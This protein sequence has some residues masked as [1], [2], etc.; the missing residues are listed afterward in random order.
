M[1][2]AIKK[3]SLEDIDYRKWDLYRKIFFIKR[4]INI[5]L[6]P[7]YILSFIIYSFSSYLTL[8]VLFNFLKLLTASIQATSFNLIFSFSIALYLISIYFIYTLYKYFVT[9]LNYFLVFRWYYKQ[10]KNRLISEVINKFISEKNKNFDSIDKFTKALE[11][12]FSTFI[13][14]FKGSTVFNLLKEVSESMRK[15]LPLLLYFSN[16]NTIL[17]TESELKVISD[18]LQNDKKFDRIRFLDSVRSVKKMFNSFKQYNEGLVPKIKP[19]FDT[20][21]FLSKHLTEFISLFIFVLIILP[22]L[23]NIMSNSAPTEFRIIGTPPFFEL[24]WVQS[25]S[26]S[27]SN[28]QSTVPLDI[29]INSF[30]TRQEIYY[31]GDIAYVDFEITNTLNIPYNITVDWIYNNSIRHI[32][33]SNIS[34]NSYNTTIQKNNWKSWYQVQEVGDWE[35]HVIIT[36]NISN[37]SLSKDA[38]TKF[39]VLK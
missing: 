15:E 5:I 21:R 33:W 29:I 18:V 9:L 3:K 13:S 35:S 27:Q 1:N 38:L 22:M 16:E 8:L 24:S 30:K 2:M 23:P 19:S 6:I 4:K 10:N 37:E 28:Q 11:I 34:T 31:S 32:G 20:G 17:K 39:R 36:Y 14:Y 25:G 26:K 12:T 7:L